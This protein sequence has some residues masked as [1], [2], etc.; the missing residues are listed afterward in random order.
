VTALQRGY[1]KPFLNNLKNEVVVRVVVPQI[2]GS[3]YAFD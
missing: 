2:E 3:L 1:S